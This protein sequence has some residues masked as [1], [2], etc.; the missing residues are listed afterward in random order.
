MKDLDLGKLR[1]ERNSSAP[2]PAAPRPRLPLSRRN[3][4][5]GLG[6]LLLLVLLLKPSAAPVQTTQVVSAWPSQ[7][8]ARL[9][10]TGFVVARN[11]AAIT[12]KTAGRLEWLGVNEGDAVKS[13][14]LLARLESRDLAASY[15]AAKANAQGAAAAVLSAASEQDDA[16][17]NVDRVEIL[18]KKKLVALLNL[19][20]ARSRLARASAGVA[21]AKAA[22]SA[23]RAN[24]E[25]ARTTLEYAQIRAP[26]DGVV[27]A[28]GANVGDIVSPGMVSADGK[29]ALLVV[30][31]M[32]TLEVAADVSESSLAEVRIGQ[33]CE[34]ALDA[35]PERRFRG[36]VAVIVPAINRASA[37]V[38]TRVRILD[39]DPAILPDMSAR[40]SFL[41]QAVPVL[42]KPVLAVNP[43]AIV[44]H[45]GQS[46][47]Y[48][49]GDDGRAHAVPVKPGAELGSVREV[50]G[51]LSA[52]TLLVL[53][54]AQVS[55]G[56]RL[57]LAEAK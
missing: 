44:E 36:E 37:T 42:D 53:N 9:N 25:V 34:I 38:T 31:D 46:L 4:L 50:S 32:S 28:R 11:R 14:Q 20:D 48:R 16:Q 52:G 56:K 7:Q 24:E 8:Y 15:E 30:A 6:V 49:I 41:S 2:K 27:I 13:G 45:D 57:K 5:I 1:V 12:A 22:Q 43:Q 54:A 29:G 35:F 39:A 19:Q 47:V 26:F 55:D 21:S 3:V 10:A 23:A 40:V 18:F 17:R 51:E 33:P